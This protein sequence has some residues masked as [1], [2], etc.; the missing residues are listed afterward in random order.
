M[1]RANRSVK[2]ERPS[3]RGASPR[4]RRRGY[5]ST[6]FRSPIRTALVAALALWPAGLRLQAQ[7][8]PAPQVEEAASVARRA[9]SGAAMG[10]GQPLENA[11]D[12][13]ALLRRAVPRKIVGQLTPLQREQIEKHLL[14][15]ISDSLV[16]A[17]PRRTHPDII[18]TDIRS[19]SP[20]SISIGFVLEY[21]T[22]RFKTRW[23]L[24]RRGAEW[25]IE[26]IHL[27]DLGISLADQAVQDLGPQ[28]V[29]KRDSI[30]E[31]RNA[32]IPR[33]LGIFGALAVG[34]V[35]G[36]RLTRSQRLTLWIGASVPILLFA[37]DGVFALH[38]ILTE[39]YELS[40][41]QERNNA[42][43]WIARAASA[44]RRGDFEEAQRSWRLAMEAGA[45]PEP[46][47]YRLGVL[48]QTRHDSAQAVAHFRRA[49][50]GRH[51][52]PG[53]LAGLAVE[54]MRAGRFDE[55]RAE[56]EQYISATGPDPDASSSLASCLAALGQDSQAEEWIGEALAHWPDDPTVL[57][58]AAHIEAYRGDAP[59]A[60]WC[61]RA[62]LKIQ[63]L[64]LRSLEEDPAFSKLADAPE[65]KAFLDELRR[66]P[67]AAAVR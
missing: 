65:W 41:P 63:P 11:L 57:A 36:R 19:S 62:L 34:F 9:A 20:D 46:V 3:R 28:A 26:D 5:H 50:S 35:F 44:S 17:E 64:D 58:T 12:R 37:V 43:M 40:F 14:A 21:G 1:V 55:A 29:R 4:N 49:L 53:A 7:R 18:T 47:E 67:P 52:A 60:V 22:K 23:D 32:L 59:R 66:A 45:A 56:W 16:L 30:R 13:A 54:A 39:P 31:A 51:A 6:V 8:V 33:A 27:A 15:A 2:N 38:R 25:R 61:L 24:A 48:A 10:R 42:E